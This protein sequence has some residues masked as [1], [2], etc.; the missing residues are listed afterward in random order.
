M[1]KAR[2]VVALIALCASAHVLGIEFDGTGAGPIPDP[3][4]TFES[5]C[6]A[7]TQFTPLVISFDVNGFTT[8]IS[9]VQLGLEFNPPHTNVGDLHVAL[10]APGDIVSVTIFGDTGGPGFGSTAHVAGPY[11]FADENDGD[12]W[13]LS[14][15]ATIPPGGYRTSVDGSATQTLLTQPFTVLSPPQI[16]GIWTLSVADDCGSDTGAVSKAALF[17]NPSLTPVRL[18][19]FDVD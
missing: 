2:G 14:N 6:S 12:W 7:A 9:H 19:N 16:N 15:Q 17:L 11:F 18:Q 5:P 4:V 8:P 10:H 1:Q 3:P 13:A